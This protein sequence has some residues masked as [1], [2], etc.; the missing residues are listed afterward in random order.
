MNKKIINCS[1]CTNYYCKDIAKNGG[2]RFW[3]CL[4]KFLYN[5][6]GPKNLMRKL[7]NEA[8][9]FLPEY[10]FFWDGCGLCLC[11]FPYGNYIWHFAVQMKQQG[12]WNY[13]EFQEGYKFGLTPQ[14]PYRDANPYQEPSRNISWDCGYILGLSKMPKEK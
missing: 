7:A 2:Y 1:V 8:Q 14:E 3:G 5:G 9:R 13:E 4:L 11:K 6:Y 10:T 12:L